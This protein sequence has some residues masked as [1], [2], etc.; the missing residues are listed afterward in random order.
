MV[1]PTYVTLERQMTALLQ[2]ILPNVELEP[3]KG[4][5]TA[6]LQFRSAITFTF[7]STAGRSRLERVG[8]LAVHFYAANPD[9]AL[10]TAYSNELLIEDA[11]KATES[12]HFTI[13][14]C[15]FATRLPLIDEDTREFINV[16]CT[17]NIQYTIRR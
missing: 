9:D 11:L 17:Y 16:E 8:E 7:A 15:T 5:D 3:V 1:T 14:G 12:E 10:A 6:D 4:E 13:A 2:G